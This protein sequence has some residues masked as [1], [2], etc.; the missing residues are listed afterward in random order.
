MADPDWSLQTKRSAVVR[1]F[2]GTDDIPLKD[3]ERVS[4]MYAGGEVF[5]DSLDMFP[6]GINRRL[7][8]EWVPYVKQRRTAQCAGTGLRKLLKRSITRRDDEEHSRRK[9]AKTES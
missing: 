7:Y 3:Y 1:S 8:A 2:D 5:L 6:I 4:G 9:R